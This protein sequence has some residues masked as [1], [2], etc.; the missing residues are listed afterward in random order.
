MNPTEF[1]NL[2]C[3]LLSSQG[4]FGYDVAVFKGLRSKLSNGHTLQIYPAALRQ[5]T[6]AENQI[7]C[8]D[9]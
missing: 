9:V 4:S 7:S 5:S 6:R 3:R 1:L 8:T 2:Q